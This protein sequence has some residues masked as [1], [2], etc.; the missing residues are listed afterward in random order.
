M[1]WRFR[2]RFSSCRRHHLPPFRIS[3]RS[4]HCD[5]NRRYR[6]EVPSSY[7]FL[8]PSRRCV[9][10]IQHMPL[11]PRSRRG[12]WLLAATVWLAACAGLLWAL[13]VVPRAKWIAPV[14]CRLV[15]VLADGTLVTQDF[16]ALDHSW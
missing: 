16:S 4:E 2:P 15:G 14:S 13:P 7:N 5:A 9:A 6:A 1:P 3:L 12:T 10:T 11:L 8:G